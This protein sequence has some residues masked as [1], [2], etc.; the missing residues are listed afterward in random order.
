MKNVHEY[1][2]DRA[3]AT[4]KLGGVNPIRK[5]IDGE[6][7]DPVQVQ[8]AHGELRFYDQGGQPLAIED[9]PEQILADLK[10]NP[11]RKGTESVEQVLRFCPICADA[12]VDNAIAS[13]D[14]ETHLIQH[15]KNAQAAAGINDDV[16]PAVSP[17][18]VA[19]GRAKVKDGAK[20]RA[21][22]RK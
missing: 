16:T 14:Y 17:T 12:G 6:K 15:A 4:A 21:S 3:T 13:N 18:A 1:T 7:Y 5:Y 22:R 8:L 9:V 19:Q 11:L 20:K 10:V 2:V